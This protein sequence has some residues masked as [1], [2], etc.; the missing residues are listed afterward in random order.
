MHLFTLDPYTLDERA[1]GI[2]DMLL[3]PRPEFYVCGRRGCDF[4]VPAL[5][6]QLC[7]MVTPRPATVEGPNPADWSRPF[8]RWPS[9]P[10]LIDGKRVRGDSVWQD[11]SL[12]AVSP[13]SATSA[14]AHW[15]CPTY[16][17]PNPDRGSGRPRGALP[18]RTGQGRRSKKG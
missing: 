7:P 11:H 17:M 3:R 2:P 15:L 8:D 9:L 10:A 1:P 13:G 4:L 6:N 16:A 18:L 12:N 14:W 5:I